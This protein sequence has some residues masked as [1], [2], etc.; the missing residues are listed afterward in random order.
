LIMHT[1]Q[2]S[3]GIGVNMVEFEDDYT[4]VA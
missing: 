4:E 2:T 3:W 1:T